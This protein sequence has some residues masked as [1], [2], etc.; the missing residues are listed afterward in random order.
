MAEN[1]ISIVII[2]DRIIYRKSQ[3]NNFDAL[4]QED[5]QLLYSTLLLNLI[6]NFEQRDFN[7]DFFVFINENDIDD[8]QNEIVAFNLSRHE[9]FTYKINDGFSLVFDKIKN[10]RQSIIVYADV[11]GF[12]IASVREFLK[13]LN[14]DDNT[15]VIGT[16]VNQSICVLG[17]NHQTDDLQL[18]I[19]NSERNYSKLLSLLKA[20][21]HFIHT[22][23]G[24]IRVNDIE[25]FKE[26]YN[27][28]SH[29]KSIEYCSQEM[30]EKFTHLFVEYK[31]LLK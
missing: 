8:I 31:D 20:E 15:I 9:I 28:L 17:F 24:F 30:H 29:K 14:S 27:N 7:S 2:S 21:D 26:L 25:S 12:G 5:L 4:S 3:E 16:S 11:M 18:A 6:N 19:Q 23:N 10:A 13:L 22:I 1:S